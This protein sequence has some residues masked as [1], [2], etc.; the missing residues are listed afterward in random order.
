M[1]PGDDHGGRQAAQAAVLG[2][3]SDDDII[4]DV[5]VV[6]REPEE[7]VVPAASERG[8][9]GL[10]Q[11]LPDVDVLPGLAVLLGRTLDQLVELVGSE[12]G[13]VPEPAVACVGPGELDA[14]VMAAVEPTFEQM[15]DVTAHHRRVG[16][17]RVLGV[18][19]DRGWLG[20]WP[21]TTGGPKALRRCALRT[22]A[23]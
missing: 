23:R 4:I 3:G 10:A 17:H 9:V 11:G 1:S 12:D 5:G 7:F 13:G 20:L 14:A 16:L 8:N 2:A 22:L 18:G 15:A 19:H 21:G 6:C